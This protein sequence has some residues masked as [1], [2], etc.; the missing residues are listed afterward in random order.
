LLISK[1]GFVELYGVNNSWP[2]LVFGF[3]IYWV[4]PYSNPFVT[5]IG[6]IT[7]SFAVALLADKY[8]PKLFCGFRNYTYQIFLM[9]IFAQMFV[10]IVYKHISAPYVVAYIICMLAG[11]YVPVVVSKVIEKI[12]WK[13]LKLCVGLK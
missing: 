11:L 12:N 13:L 5:T 6:G 10:K 9:G 7:I 3:L 4:G 8:V 1:E 2:L